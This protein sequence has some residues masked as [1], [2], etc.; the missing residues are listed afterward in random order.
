MRKSTQESFDEL[1][2][3]WEELWV[4]VFKAFGLDKFNK[5]LGKFR[6]FK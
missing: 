2:E 4:Q 5:W 6:M 3:A 1:N